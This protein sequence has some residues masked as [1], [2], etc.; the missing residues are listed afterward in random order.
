MKHTRSL[1]LASRRFFC[2]A[3]WAAAACV[4]LA[5]AWSMPPAHAQTPPGT[6]A[7]ALIRD[8]DEIV[9]QLD[10]AQYDA[11]WRG[12]APFV[13]TQM[14]QA[15]FVK[16]IKQARQ[17]MGPV[18]QRGWSNV[19]RIALS[20]SQGAPE[21]MY[22]NVDYV[23]TLAS[24]QVVFEQLSF[25]LEPDGQWRLTGYVP[26]RPVPAAAAQPASSPA[27]QPRS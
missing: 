16:P 4:A 1:A 24:G 3:R 12:M 25:R 9:K 23:T 26:R 13:H 22:A 6:S 21:G 17:A 15:Q 5:S 27:S 11:V 14:K 19:A 8:A 20:G 10:A 2:F 7:D 18:A